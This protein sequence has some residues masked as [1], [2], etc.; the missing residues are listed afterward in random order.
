MVNYAMVS[1]LVGCEFIALGRQILPT[2]TD[3]CLA[4]SATISHR[5]DR[6]VLPLSE[7][8]DCVH[9]KLMERKMLQPNRSK[10]LSHSCCS[11]FKLLSCSTSSEYSAKCNT[12]CFSATDEVNC[13]SPRDS[14]RPEGRV[15]KLVNSICVTVSAITHL[16]DE[17]SLKDRCLSC[18]L[19][20]LKVRHPRCDVRVSGVTK[21]G[22]LRELITDTSLHFERSHQLS[23]ANT[24]FSSVT[25]H[26]TWPSR[27]QNNSTAKLLRAAT[28]AD[29]DLTTMSYSDSLE[30]V[31]CDPHCG[32]DEEEERTNIAV[33]NIAVELIQKDK[34]CFIVSIDQS[35]EEGDILKKT[36]CMEPAPENE[37][38]GENTQISDPYG[39]N[40]QLSDPYVVVDILQNDPYGDDICEDW[41]DGHESD[42]NN[43]STYTCDD[44]P[45][46]KELNSHC[47]SEINKSEIDK[48]DV[49]T[50]SSKSTEKHKNDVMSLCDWSFLVESR[51]KK[52]KEKSLIKE[53]V[54]S[55]IVCEKKLNDD[56]S[57]CSQSH[58]DM[59]EG[60][61]DD[62]DYDDSEGVEDNDHGSVDRYFM[63]QMKKKKKLHGK[64]V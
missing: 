21:V 43:T 49:Y 57:S 47:E 35:S 14:M 42:E 20:G 10:R 60:V 48:V 18:S 9:G 5:S 26:S 28:G 51:R 25:L 16:S 44:A 54:I 53:I 39:N 63:N 7:T 40:T 46:N 8:I 15:K 62:Y 11:A 24:A 36:S 31:S 61:E 22:P 27:W 30:I 12:S 2:V 3:M 19:D 50:V 13:N 56:V 6:M 41:D 45:E 52:K 29:I 32:V 4:V 17:D 34:N 23:N 58:D 64:K 1:D 38:Y 33:G 37:S 59:R 55:C